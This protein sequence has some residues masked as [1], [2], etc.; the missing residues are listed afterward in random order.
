MNPPVPDRPG[1]RYSRLNMLA[2]SLSIAALALAGC[3]ASASPDSQSSSVINTSVSTETAS[4]FNSD[5]VHEIN[6]EV[7]ED[8]VQKALKAYEDD[9]SKEWVSATVT[10]DG[11]EFTN[12]GLR[13]KGN[14]TLRQADTSSNAAD[15]PWQIRLDKYVKGQS[16]SGRTQFVVRTNNSQTSLNEAVALELLGEAGLA[17]EHAAAT[18][19][20]FNGKDAQLRLVI[21]N[22]SDELYSQE[23]FN[24]DGITYK[25]D[26]SGDYS[27]R[28]DQGS[29]YESAFSVESGR[30]VLTPVAEFLNF[31][32]NSSD[33]DFASQL[34]QKLDVNQFAA[35][36][37][38]QDLVSNSD[39]IDGPGNNSY[40][41]Y[42][43]SNGTMTVVAWDQNLSFGGMGWG[44]NPDG[45]QNPGRRQDFDS[46]SL[47]KQF[48]PDGADLA[49]AKT[50]ILK[51]V[52]P[53][54]AAL[55]EGMALNSGAQL[56]T[57]LKSLVEGKMPN[58]ITFQGMDPGNGKR[59]Q[60]PGGQDGAK[61]DDAQTQ[62]GRGFG[63]KSNPLVTR[64]LANDEF[65][66]KVEQA[67]SELK[68]KLYDSGTA[69]KILDKWSTLLTEQA[70][71]L[72]D[73]ET[74]ASES[75]KIAAYFTADVSSSQPGSVQPRSE[76]ED[77]PS[78]NAST[79]ADQS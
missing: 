1:R 44:K 56:I 8:S 28:G 65:N 16:Y 45:G 31:V 71:D 12:V 2:A 64:F 47:L 63:S 17:T 9:Q 7:S 36:L 43:Q 22:P 46:D 78:S 73:A 70:V 49:D 58:D 30:E 18:R 38:M 21:D 40:L 57:V 53:D 77:E 14:S 48:L 67:K 54:G 10:I 50:Q 26:A 20:T 55:P 74:I 59:P 32:N 6:V 3:S 33:E 69:K 24:E 75:S 68:T 23:S 52:L 34:A 79:L 15:L 19:F 41:R 25:A 66:A 37:A 4:F 62:G 5:K 35:Y 27:Y 42:D 60:M 11:K 13:L 61:P 29:D 72:V 39:D 51:G 76:E